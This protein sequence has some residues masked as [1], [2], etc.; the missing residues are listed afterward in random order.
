MPGELISGQSDFGAASGLRPC[1]R[2]RVKVQT[3]YGK[4]R[5]KRKRGQR[6]D[7]GS[8]M[9]RETEK[10]ENWTKKT[11]ERARVARETAWE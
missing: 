3:E 6:K 9:K 4:N 7:V 8:G 5:T 1:E 10:I 2:E 11:K